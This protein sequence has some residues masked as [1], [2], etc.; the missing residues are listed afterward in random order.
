M[1]SNLPQNHCWQEKQ[2]SPHL[3]AFIKLSRTIPSLE[4]S[5]FTKQNYFFDK[6]E[7]NLSNESQHNPVLCA[8]RLAISHQSPQGLVSAPW[9]PVIPSHTGKRNTVDSWTW[10]RLESRRINYQRL[11]AAPPTIIKIPRL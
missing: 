5:P 3:A 4:V 9:H 1:T 10:E 11:S 2:F 8:D 6:S 7:F